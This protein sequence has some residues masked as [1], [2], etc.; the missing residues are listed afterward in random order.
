MPTTIT[1]KPSIAQHSTTQYKT[2][3]QETPENF[4]RILLGG[5]EVEKVPRHS[6]SEGTEPACYDR[7]CCVWRA[8]AAE[9]LIWYQGGVAI[10]VVA[11]ARR[12]IRRR[13]RVSRATR[14]S[15]GTTEA[16]NESEHTF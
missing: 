3:Q 1:D 8:V 2:E 14:N 7:T 4:G 5:V 9:E 15:C 12:A 13:M 11:R 16:M 6:T 10:I